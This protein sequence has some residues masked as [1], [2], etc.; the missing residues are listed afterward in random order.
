V[1]ATLILLDTTDTLW[2]ALGVGQNP[3]GS[4]TF[5]F[6]LFVPFGQILASSGGM[7]FF[8]THDA[9]GQLTGIAIGNTVVL[10]HGR[11]TSRYSNSFA[12]FPR[13]PAGQIG[14]L[15]KGS[16]LKTAV[17]LVGLGRFLLQA[18]L[19]FF[20]RDNFRT[21]RLGTCCPDA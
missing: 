18:G 19:H 21:F 7:G 5:I 1:I 6:A 8:A 12:T 2:T 4:F 17:A 15:D 9:K 13:T 20:F 11:S 10:F 3:I 16:Q 14:R